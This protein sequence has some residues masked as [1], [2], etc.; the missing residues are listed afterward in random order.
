MSTKYTKSYRPDS[1]SELRSPHRMRGMELTSTAPEAVLVKFSSITCFRRHIN[2]MVWISFTSE[3]SGSQW[4]WAV[5]TTRG[6]FTWASL[7]ELAVTKQRGE[8]G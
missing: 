3:N 6:C 5:A 8:R 2:I 4:M 1:G 7:K